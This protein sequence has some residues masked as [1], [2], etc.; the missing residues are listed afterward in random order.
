MRLESSE[1]PGKAVS[2][3]TAGCSLWET[4][5]L[6]ENQAEPKEMLLPPISPN[7]FVLIGVLSLA[8]GKIW[9]IANESIL[10]PLIQ[11]KL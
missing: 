7:L 3:A 4:A 11:A 2:I 8:K 5:A 1:R 6:S 10:R 9:H